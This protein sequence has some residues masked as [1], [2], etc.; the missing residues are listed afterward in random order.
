ME[1]IPGVEGNPVV[2]DPAVYG[3]V[4]YEGIPVLMAKSIPKSIFPPLQVYSSLV[5]S[6][7]YCWERI[8]GEVVFLIAM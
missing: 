3:A 8:G 4:T 5:H 7:I 1:H 6:N 2:I